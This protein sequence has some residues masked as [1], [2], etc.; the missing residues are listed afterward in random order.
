MSNV[1][2]VVVLPAL[3][4]ATQMKVAP[5]SGMAA[6]KEWTW[7]GGPELRTFSSLMISTSGFGNP[8]VEVH[9]SVMLSPTI[10]VPSEPVTVAMSAL[11]SWR[12]WV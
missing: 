6:A 10:P 11:S 3:F 1:S 9:V 5:S 8:P 12:E 2:D 7:G 4:D